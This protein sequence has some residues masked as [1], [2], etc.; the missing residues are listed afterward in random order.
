MILDIQLG[1][2][3]F[4]VPRRGDFSFPGMVACKVEVPPLQ[5]QV[6]R[7][8]RWPDPAVCLKSLSHNPDQPTPLS[9]L[10]A[11]SSVV[12]GDDKK[13]RDCSR[14]TEGPWW[15]SWS[16]VRG[17]DTGNYIQRGYSGD[18]AHGQDQPPLSWHSWVLSDFGLFACRITVQF[19]ALTLSTLHYLQVA[20]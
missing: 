15:W 20:V 14:G 3:H 7:G 4:K 17:R 10:C 19:P 12:C 18:A 2:P 6:G 5:A 1:L 11:C 16:W 13:E 8:S 9:P